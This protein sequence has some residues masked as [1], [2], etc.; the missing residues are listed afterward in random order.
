MKRL[1]KW[2]FRL[3]FLAATVL[4]LA[5]VFRDAILKAVAEHQIRAET[6][7]DAR[8]GKFHI[9]LREPVV[10]LENLKIYN[11]DEFG[12]GPLVNLPELHIEYDRAALL[13]QKLRL[14]LVRFNLAE[15]NVVENRNGKTN[16][17]ALQEKQK[18]KQKETAARGRKVGVPVEF[19]GIDTLKLTLGQVRFSSM[20]NP[21]NGRVIALDMKDYELKHV[22]SAADLSGL[23]LVL[24]IK[25]G[26]NF[27]G[28]GIPTSPGAAIPT[29]RGGNGNPAQATQSAPGGNAQP[30]KKRQ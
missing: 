3:L 18:Q 5:V 1:V 12:G 7:L 8:V 9:G 2:L 28:T 30:L 22:K 13:S 24:M 4:V 11:T 14:T 16:V 17:E 25:T 26:M 6:G 19:T 27:P 10:R 20:K 29:V 15:V 21:S 23:L